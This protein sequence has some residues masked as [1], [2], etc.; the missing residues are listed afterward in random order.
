M[1][2]NKGEDA[3]EIEH[4]YS[5]GGKVNW[6][7]NY[8][9]LWRLLQKLEKNYHVIQQSHSLVY[10]Q[11]KQKQIIEEVSIPNVHCSIVHYNQN[12]KTTLDE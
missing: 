3:E 11:R 8:R 4:L 12:M 10:I 6:Y 1:I 9:K 2:N 5:V 7:S